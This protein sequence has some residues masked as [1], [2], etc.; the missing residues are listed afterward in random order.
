MYYAESS[1]PVNACVRCYDVKLSGRFKCG[2]C[3]CTFKTKPVKDTSLLPIESS[4]TSLLD[5]KYNNV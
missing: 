4:S 2:R 3:G 5:R 1:L